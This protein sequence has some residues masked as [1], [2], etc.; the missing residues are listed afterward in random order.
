MDLILPTDLE[1]FEADLTPKQL[2]G[3]MTAL[4]Q[5]AVRLNEEVTFGTTEAG[6]RHLPLQPA[7]AHAQVRRRDAGEAR[8]RPSRALGM[9]TA[10]DAG[11]ADFTGIHVPDAT[12]D[13]I[14]IA[15]V[16]HQA[17]ID[18]DETGTE[19]AAATA[20]GMDTGGCTGPLQPRRSRFRL[21]HPFLF[22]LRDLETGAIL[23]MGRVVDPS[24]KPLITARM[25]S[26]SS[27]TV[28]GVG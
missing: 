11:S 24:I 20:V 2:A 6:L 28:G 23:F 19:A 26:V 7:T 27:R 21:D 4:D 13:P 14:Y 5:G 10:F 8:R 1:S 18:V 25:W 9:P 16:I 17:N 15:D 12:E 3:I 22:V